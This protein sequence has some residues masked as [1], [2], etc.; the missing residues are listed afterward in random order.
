LPCLLHSLAA[1]MAITAEAFQEMIKSLDKDG[2][3]EVSCQEYEDCYR[4]MFPQVTHERFMVIWKRMDVNGDGNLTCQELADYYGFN[5]ESG[6]ANEM[7]DEQI[8]ETLQMQATLDIESKIQVTGDEKT[9]Q[10]PIAARDASIVVYKLGGQE[11]RKQREPEAQA[12]TEFLEACMI[13][14]LT[15]V[16]ASKPTVMSYLRRNGNVRVQDQKSEMPLHK[17]ARFKVTSEKIHVFRDCLQKLIEATRE[18]AA[19]AGVALRSDLNHQDNNGKTPLYAAVEHGNTVMIETLLALNRSESADPLI[20]NYQNWTVLHAAV[21]A[22]DLHVLQS[23]TKYITP[24]RVKV[25]LMSMSKTG[26]NPLHISAYH[27]KPEVVQFLMNLGAD[28]TRVDRFGNTAGKL[29]ERS[30]RADAKMIV[31]GD[32]SSFKKMLI[33]SVTL[34]KASA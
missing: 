5:L 26:R 29:A 32:T 20:V 9:A 22:D 12:A 8:L 27:S 15:N 17:L 16:D 10:V 33:R 13:G 24:A 14:D 25:M 3:G 30:G 7:T 4:S 31:D 18:Q 21:H 34:A 2:D 28:R 11:F 19:A 1:I 6:V 23:L